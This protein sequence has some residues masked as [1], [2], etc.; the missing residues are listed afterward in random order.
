M[1]S[2]EIFLTILLEVARY[3]E[4][5]PPPAGSCFSAAARNLVF[6]QECRND[7]GGGAGV[8]PTQ[9]G[10]DPGG[11]E[12]DVPGLLHFLQPGKCRMNVFQGMSCLRKWFR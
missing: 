4:D 8:V 10:R 7:V 9:A 5:A 3:L 11:G 6:P 2:L 12:K 1:Q